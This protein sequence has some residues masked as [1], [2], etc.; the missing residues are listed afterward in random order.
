MAENNDLRSPRN[1]VGT[2]MFSRNTAVTPEGYAYYQDDKDQRWYPYAN[3]AQYTGVPLRQKPGGSLDFQIGYRGYAAQPK[4]TTLYKKGTQA[5]TEGPGIDK[6]TYFPKE[7]YNWDEQIDYNT[8]PLDEW[9][10]QEKVDHSDIF[11]GRTAEAYEER[12]GNSAHLQDY[13]DTLN[14]VTGGGLSFLSPTQT[15]RNIYNIVNWATD[16]EV[17]DP[18]LNNYQGGYRAMTWEDVSNQYVY[19]NNGIFKD[20]FAQ[21]HPIIT[22]LGNGVADGIMIGGPKNTTRAFSNAAQNTSAAIKNSVN[23]ARTNYLLRNSLKNFGDF[24]GQEFKTYSYKNWWNQTV[25]QA[26][27]NSWYR[28][29]GSGNPYEVISEQISK[30]D[31]L[32]T[33][34]ARLRLVAESEAAGTPRNG[35]I[36]AAYGKPWWEFE[37][38]LFKFP[39]ETFKDM[40]ST[41]Q[42]GFFTNTS[43][44]EVENVLNGIGEHAIGPD[45]QIYN[46]SYETPIYNRR[47][48]LT[49]SKSEAA[50]LADN[51]VMSNQ[52]TLHPFD[53]SYALK[54]GGYEV[55]SP[56]SEAYPFG[57]K[58][59]MLPLWK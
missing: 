28:T 41:N 48:R 44:K 29:V 56:P 23:T 53:Y 4:N 59:Q 39:E 10:P 14:I 5:Y 31:K 40:P 6:Y 49:Y 51:R 46:P 25:N 21:E 9:T 27:P 50:R 8:L 17:Y 57:S 13:S 12:T 35:G 2:T 43:V 42:K 45:G 16:G 55:F 52:T 30:A 36:F 11:R 32:T 18:T 34:K 26:D 20:K 47:G 24:S 19:G 54:N 7:V 1:I 37:G 3:T 22:T 58:I 33:N 38:T 15:G